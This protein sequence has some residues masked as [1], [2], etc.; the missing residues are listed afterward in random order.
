MISSD[1]LRDKIDYKNKKIHPLLC[2]LDHN[3]AEC[4]LSIKIIEVFND[5]Y[6]NKSSKEKLNYMVKLLEHTYKDY[7][8]VRGLYSILEK[9]CTFK[10]VFEDDRKT[11]VHKNFDFSPKKDMV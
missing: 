6:S 10:S 9:K 3:S 8:L 4:Q 1:L 7:K 11:D 5:C 2:T